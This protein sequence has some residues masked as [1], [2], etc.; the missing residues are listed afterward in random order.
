MGKIPSSLVDI[1]KYISMSPHLSTYYHYFGLINRYL[2]LKNQILEIKRLMKTDG[3]VEV[4]SGRS[5]SE[6]L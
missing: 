5:Y 6:D 4:V 2:S 3:L 1:D